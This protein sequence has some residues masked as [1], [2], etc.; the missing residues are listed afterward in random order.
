[1]EN[2]LLD[3]LIWFV[4]NSRFSNS[5]IPAG[6]T[7]TDLQRELNGLERGKFI[8][9]REVDGQRAFPLLTVLGLLR[10]DEIKKSGIYENW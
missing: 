6:L 1:M 5:P 3:K 7:A 4:H 10:L 2:I 9:W 8:Y